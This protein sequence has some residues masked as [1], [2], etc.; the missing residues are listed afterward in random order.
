MACA[1]T[2]EELNAQFEDIQE[3]ITADP[4]ISPSV[5]QFGDDCR[6]AQNLKDNHM[7]YAK[8][9]SLW[10]SSDKMY[11]GIRYIRG[12]GN[13]F[14]RSASFGIHEALLRDRALASEFLKRVK[15]L[16]SR[17]TND[18]GSAVE[19]FCDYALDLFERLASGTCS[20]VEELHRL[21]TGETSEYVLYFYRY[22]VSNYIRA[23]SD[24]F[25]PFVVGLGYD[26]L[27]AFCYSEVEAL[28]SESD[29]LQL[30]AFAQCFGVRIT[31][32]YLDCS[33]VESATRHTFPGVEKSINGTSDN[34]NDVVEV[35]LLYRP[36]HYDLLYK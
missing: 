2:V 4:L 22:A 29:H 28:G 14:Y 12:D 21:S 30:V 6:I 19:D 15:D 31:V 32:E 1:P 20:T 36:G 26:T 3:E 11:S 8:L 16:S 25:L 23:H 13:C 10:T 34:V 17:L 7:L 35:T 18:Y 9:V 27:Q 33:E 24:E 5:D